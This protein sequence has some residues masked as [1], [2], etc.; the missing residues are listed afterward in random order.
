[1]ASLHTIVAWIPMLDSDDRAS[2]EAMTS[3]FADKPI[4][5]LW[6]GERLL[7]KEVSRSLA[8]EPVAWDIYLFYPPE[9]EWTDTG[10]PPPAK[11]LAQSLGG[12]IA[13]K[14]TLPPKGD[15][16]PVPKAYA[17]RVDV[18]GQPAELAALL[19]AVAVPLVEQTRRSAKPMTGSDRQPD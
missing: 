19:S 15:Q 10:I 7:G 8:I 1:V 13:T 3:T 17:G 9:A 4:P 5:Q 11:V 18:V 12:V 6:D 2:A 16:T 14:G